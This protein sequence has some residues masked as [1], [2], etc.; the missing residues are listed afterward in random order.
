MTVRSIVVASD[1][2]LNREL[3]AE[4]C[5]RLDRQ[6]RTAGGLHALKAAESN[7]QIY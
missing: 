5:T 2:M 4:I 7:R 3:M 1:E 6:V